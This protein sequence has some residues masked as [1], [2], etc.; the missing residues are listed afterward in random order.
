MCSDERKT[1]F[2]FDIRHRNILTYHTNSLS[3]F[4]DCQRKLKDIIMARYFRKNISFEQ[5]QITPE[6]LLILKFISRD[7]KTS[8][9]ITEEE[10]IMGNTLDKD[11]ISDCLKPL[12]QK[13]YL[14]YR[15]STTSGKS[16]Y[17][18][19]SKSE[20]LLTIN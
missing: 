11:S 2:P 10:K 3:D 16:Y 13:G 15:Y 17:Q 4:K 7:Q 14:E 5:N 9:A 12:T 18:I 19:T 20:K 8:Y 6:E 1:D